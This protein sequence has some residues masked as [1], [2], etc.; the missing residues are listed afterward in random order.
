MRHFIGAFLDDLE[1]DRGV[2]TRTRHGEF[3]L[4]LNPCEF[5]GLDEQRGQGQ[6]FPV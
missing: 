1:K 2:T 6:E 4:L 5:K 3:A